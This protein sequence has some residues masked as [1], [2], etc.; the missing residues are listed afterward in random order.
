MYNVLNS[1]NDKKFVED[2]FKQITSDY[3]KEGEYQKSQMKYN[4][5]CNYIE[6]LFTEVVDELKL[7]SNEIDIYSED[8]DKKKCEIFSKE[9]NI[10]D[11]N[12]VPEET[13]KENMKYI[14]LALLHS[15]P[16]NTTGMIDFKKLKRGDDIGGVLASMHEMVKIERDGFF[17]FINFTKEEAKFEENGVE[18]KVLEIHKFTPMVCVYGE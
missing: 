6:R 4:D 1:N 15:I 10:I 18:Y 2:M 14:M 12:E 3:V 7:K 16:K 17:L 13:L 9:F 11:Y 5:F 8:F